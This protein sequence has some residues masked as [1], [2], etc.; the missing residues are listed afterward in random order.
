MKLSMGLLA[1]AA[2]AGCGE[3]PFAAADGSGSSG[4]SGGSS[5]AGGSAGSGGSGG[6][7]GAGGSEAPASVREASA[8]L[9]RASCAYYERCV[10][11]SDDF[12]GPETCTALLTDSW[13]RLVES[14]DTRFTLAEMDSC[15]AELSDLSCSDVDCTYELSPG[16]LPNGAACTSALE[17]ENGYCAPVGDGCNI[18]TPNSKEGDP[19][20]NACEPGLVCTAGF[21]RKMVFDGDACDEK[22]RPCASRHRC[23]DGV[24]VRAA[25]EGEACSRGGWPQ[26]ESGFACNSDTLICTPRSY[27]GDGEVCPEVGACAVGDCKTVPGGDS[28][29]IARALP[30]EACGTRECAGGLPCEHGVCV[31]PSLQPSCD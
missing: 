6:S 17:C 9:A 12:G 28:V 19:C 3:E 1:L 30:G 8:R 13:V 26:C 27:V 20:D 25:K 24:C 15:A 31:W 2:L 29:C 23:V 10:T 5:G 4:G 16:R 21:C 22:L 18:C 7:S 14:P 11:W